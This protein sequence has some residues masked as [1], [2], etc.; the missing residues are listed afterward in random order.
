MTLM[1]V[2]LRNMVT[3]PNHLWMMRK[4]TLERM[5]IAPKTV[6]MKKMSSFEEYEYYASMDSESSINE[7]QNME[8]VDDASEEQVKTTQERISPQNLVDVDI[9]SEF[10]NGY[11]KGHPGSSRGGGIIR[12][13]YGDLITAYVEFYGEGSN[14]KVEAKVILKGRQI[15]IINGHINIMVESN[16]MVI[17]SLINRIRKPP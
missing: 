8:K 2:A 9:I 6:T 5:G 16:S 10:E 17:I 3:N 13:H 11:S 7:E 1:T 4:V 15:C 14:N 12:Y